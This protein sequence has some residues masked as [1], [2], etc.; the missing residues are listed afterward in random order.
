MIPK[1]HD[2][3]RIFSLNLF[4]LISETLDRLKYQIPFRPRKVQLEVTNKCNLDCHMCPREVMDIEL[5]H[6]DWNIFQTTVDQ[7]K[8]DVEITLTGWGEPFLHPKIFDMI[9]YCKERGHKVCITSNGIF[10]RSDIPEKIIESGIDSLTFSIDSVES[11]LLK[12]HT[13]PKTLE[14]IEKIASLREN[15]KPYFRLQATL[16][17][18]EE[19]ELYE[20]IR[21]GAK[22]KIDAV[23]VGRIDRKYDPY[24][25]RPSAAEEKQ[26]FKV[27]NRIAR[28]EGIQLDWLQFAVSSGIQ[29]FFYKLLKSKLHQGGQY[30]LKTFDYT[31]VN[32]QGDVTPCCL[33]PKVRMGNVKESNLQAIWLN[34][35]Y[36]YFRENYRETCGSC[37]LWTIDMVDHPKEEKLEPTKP[38]P[39]Q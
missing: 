21:Y 12:G 8:S 18:D 37:D 19:Q 35:H 23:N 25:K 16:H 5:E 4:S 9:G 30:C 32:R 2:F 7:L 10:P 29:R 28:K 11:N 13:N 6:M 20:V 14:S 15:G 24:L 31:Y 22:L 38:V 17:K 26:I 33:L 3:W 39:A 36:S 27:A 34:G 1:P